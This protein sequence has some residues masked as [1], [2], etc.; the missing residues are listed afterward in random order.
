MNLPRIAGGHSQTMEHL[1]A[2]VD[3]AFKVPDFEML[4]Y[5]HNR[6]QRVTMN[7]PNMTISM[8]LQAKDD[9][10]DACLKDWRNCNKPAD[11]VDSFC[12]FITTAP[13]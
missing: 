6:C 10:L 4:V 2:N 7:L 13:S 1:Q 12:P 9:F 8:R 5:R 11:E 3:R